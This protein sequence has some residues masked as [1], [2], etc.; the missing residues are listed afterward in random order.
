MKKKNLVMYTLVLTLILITVTSCGKPAIKDSAAEST[1]DQM[2]SQMETERL[3][4]SDAKNKL[5]LK[6]EIVIEASEVPDETN[7][8]NENEIGLMMAGVE[9][10]NE[11]E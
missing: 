5:N 4:E 1:P 6:D 8:T 9:G 3:T 10:G 2:E 11:H 7:E